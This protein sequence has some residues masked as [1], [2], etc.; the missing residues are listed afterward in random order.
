MIN[1]RAIVT[2]VLL[3]AVLSV[4]PARSDTS[5][6]DAPLDYSAWAVDATKPGLLLPPVGR[7]LFDYLVT[8]Q[9]G[10]RKVYR[11]PYPFSALVERIQRELTQTEYGGGTR[12]AMIPLGR[13]LQRSAAAPDFFKHPRRVFAVTGE[14]KTGERSPGL[15][16]KD[17]LYLGYVETTNTIEVISYNEAA[18]RF[19]FQ[20]VKDYR[21]DAEPKV[22]YANRAICI[23][24][25]QNHGPI[26]SKAVWSESNANSRVA[27][28]LAQSR[29][30]FYDL[31]PQAHLDFPDDIGQATVRANA[32]IT[33][34]TLWQRGCESVGDLA[35]SRR[36]RAA[37]LVAL[38]Q[39]A[40]SGELDL[41]AGAPRYQ[42]DFVT[43]F[44]ANWRR[45]WPQGLSIAQAELP[46][47]SPLGGGAYSSA[48]SAPMV[49]D[50]I[51]AAHVP[52]ALDPL[53]LRL[54]R[55]TWRFS[56][57][58]DAYRFIV[59][60]SRFF[61]AADFCT[62]DAQ[63]L[64]RGRASEVARTLH[65]A[66]CVVTPN[67]HSSFPLKIDCDASGGGG[68]TLRG[69]ISP[70]A[71]GQ[72]DLVNFGPSGQVRDA[73]LVVEKP[74]RIGD[75]FVQH[76]TL[77]RKGLTARLADG[78]AVTDVVLRWPAEAGADLHNG[79]KLAIE[80]IVMNDF[81]LLR[82]AADE[83]LH[84]QPG[85]FDNIALQRT[86][87]LRALYAKLGGAEQA[88]CCG[89]EVAMPPAVVESAVGPDE[90]APQL[91]PFYHNCATCHLSAEHFPPNFLAGD[92]TRVDANLRHCAPRLLVRLA[93]WQQAPE[94]RVKSPMPPPTFL[95]A[96]GSTPAHWGLGEEFHA[97]RRY[98]E[99]LVKAQGRSTQ[100]DELLKDGYE[101][102]P[103]CLPEVANSPVSGN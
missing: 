66:K 70:S 33:Q 50:F 68:F 94:Q 11:V 1:M 18:G 64:Q 87:M 6:N 36:C 79:T 14:P 47:R 97:L 26:F 80:L 38:M 27:E 72:I 89:E 24:C 86:V 13:S 67:P 53:N 56:G 40:L 61:T 91:Q 103:S 42:S 98:V 10:E 90:T 54:P 101:S 82:Q 2:A 37:A 100:L 29:A 30:D 12:V 4:T 17:R 43:T 5:A 52:A 83:L 21:A 20:L 93:A 46:D 51:A 32:L 34:Q 15:L 25:H 95:A 58:L 41:G 7:S 85:L 39:Y 44:G 78:R 31:P 69:Q 55:E 35:Q 23:S 62:L 74:Q 71:N 8:E 16:L 76:V 60:W 96:L 57:A 81:A 88:W 59:G 73:Q 84:E 3:S 99:D 75:R 77:Q 48:S 49:T 45:Q 63:V 28:L 92:A 65:T 9:I 22:F 102:L 19:E